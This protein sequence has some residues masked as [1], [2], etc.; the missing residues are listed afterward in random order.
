VAEKDRMDHG[1]NIGDLV[2]WYQN[3]S[4]DNKNAIKR[5]LSIMG[6]GI[7]KAGE[8]IAGSDPVDPEAA[9]K[10]ASDAE[11]DDRDGVGYTGQAGIEKPLRLDMDDNEAFAKAFAT[12]GR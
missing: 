3:L 7:S 10:A 9:R 12:Y 4:A 1:T 5:V 6:G 8:W 11:T 2:E